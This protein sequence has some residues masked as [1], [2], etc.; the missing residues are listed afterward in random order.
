MFNIYGFLLQIIQFALD[1]LSAVS[2]SSSKG[3]WGIKW[4]PRVAA[5]GTWGFTTFGNSLLTMQRG[6]CQEY[7]KEE[8]TNR[9]SIYLSLYVCAAH[10]HRENS[11]GVSCAAWLNKLN[12]SYR[13]AVPCFVPVC[14]AA[15][16]TESLLWGVCPLI[17]LPLWGKSCHTTCL[18]C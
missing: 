15:W 2:S 7:E 4:I 12:E 13:I 8:E 1:G 16:L 14:H 9:K 11:T 6:H 18:H 3:Q 17:V 5:E 10:R